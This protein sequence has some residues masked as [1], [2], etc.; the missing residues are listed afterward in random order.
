[1]IKCS[2]CDQSFEID[3]LIESRKKM[4]ELYHTY[5]GVNNI[6][7]KVKWLEY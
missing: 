5:R 2:L 1:M 4:H 7:G 6:V 3:D